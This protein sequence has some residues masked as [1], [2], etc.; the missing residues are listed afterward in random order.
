MTARGDGVEKGFERY[1]HVPQRCPNCK[2]EL[3]TST[4]CSGAE[5]EPE[6]GDFTVCFYCAE[7]LRF[8]PEMRLVFPTHDG[9]NAFAEK[10]PRDFASL[11]K[12]KMLVTQMLIR[13]AEMN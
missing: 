13:K 3:D 7:V 6:E 11:L 4:E 10:Q 2:R 9:M 5:V 1:R 12:A 8:G